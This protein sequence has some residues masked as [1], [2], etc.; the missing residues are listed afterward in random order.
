[1]ELPQG[2]GGSRQQ[3]PGV[4]RAFASA[5]GRDRILLQDIR[6]DIR[7]V[8][9]KDP[10]ARSVL[11][12]LT[13]PGLHAL[14]L[15]RISHW[16]WKRNF[17][18]A[19]RI[20]SHFARFLTGVEIHPGA[21][22]GRRFFI[23]HGMGVVIGETAVVG[24][25]VLLYH[26]VTLGGVSLEK[27]KRHPTLGNNVLVGMG[28]KI[29]GPISIGDGTRVGANA[30]VNKDIPANC[31]VVGIPG[32]IVRRDGQRIDEVLGANT[33]MDNAMNAVDPQDS[34]IREMRQRIDLLEQHSEKL[35][36]L[37]A[38]LEDQD[39]PRWEPR[40]DRP[41]ETRLTCACGADDCRH[42]PP[43]WR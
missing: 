27:T 21:V 18:S 36:Q 24:D 8:F 20:L 32:R 41:N 2:R 43:H 38:R 37:I 5:I 30:V 12:V 9:E 33:V 6:E 7:T 1:M 25:D 39:G 34:T 23:D 13:Y 16:L 4:F 35:E 42:E 3:N 11:E 28:A 31:T 26:Q 10:A 14:W 17:K 19:A 22:I 40:S 29:L 15:H